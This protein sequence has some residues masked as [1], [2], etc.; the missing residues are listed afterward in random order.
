MKYVLA[1]AIYLT[2]A[3]LTGGYYANHRCDSFQEATRTCGFD[4]A[5]AGYAWPA[6]WAARG[7]LVVTR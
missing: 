2:G 6:Y 1:A 7:A 5:L 3:F 4:S